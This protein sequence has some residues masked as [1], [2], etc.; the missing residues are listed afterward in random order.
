MKVYTLDVRRKMLATIK[1]VESETRKASRRYDAAALLAK[2]NGQIA[3]DSLTAFLPGGRLSQ[4][5]TA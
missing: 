4:K 5:E 2:Q 1:K 3:P